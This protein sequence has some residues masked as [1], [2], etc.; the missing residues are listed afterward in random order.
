MKDYLQKATDEKYRKEVYD[1]W[2]KLIHDEAPM[3]PIHYTFD[4]TGLNKRVKNFNLDPGIHTVTSQWKDVTVTSEKTRSRKII[5]K[6]ALSIYLLLRAI[7]YL[8][9]F[10]YY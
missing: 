10:S 8:Q 4:L 1:K 9:S 3:I 2:Q 6:I 5:I 7:F